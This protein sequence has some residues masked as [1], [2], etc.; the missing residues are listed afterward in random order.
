VFP[1]NGE[2]TELSIPAWA[3]GSYLIRDFAAQVENLR[4]SGGS[5]RTLQATKMSKNSWLIDTTEE[6]HFA[7]T[8]DIWAGMLN[9]STSWV[10]P[11][12]ALLNGSSI[13]MYTS[14]SRN[15]PQW[16][17]LNL[18]DDWQNVNTTLDPGAEP[19]SFLARDFDELV[20][21]PIL[22]G[23]TQSHDFSVDEQD[24]ALVL[25]TPNPF[26]DG[27]KS[28]EDLAK[29]VAAQQ[30][31][32]Q[33]NPFQKKYLFMNLFMGP[34]GGLEHDNSTVLM[35]DPLAM[36][37]R[38]QYIR[39]LGLVSHEFFH[40]WNV[41]RMRPAA[42][43]NYDY[44]R[45]MYTR[46]LWL[47]EGLSSYYDNLLLLRAGL[48]SV[49]E[50]L[51]LLA[52]EIRTYETTPG[53]EVRSAEM[54][55]F[56]TWIKHYRQDENSVNST[57]SYYRKGALI[58]F[59][60][61][62]AIRRATKGD[63]SLDTVM[64]R[65]YGRYS[66]PDQG[67]Y[68]PG[69]FED[70]VEEIAGPEVRAMVDNMLRS[71]GDPDV[72]QALAW[73]GL[74]LIRTPGDNTESGSEVISPAGLGVI[75]DDEASQL[76]VEQVVRGH[77]ASSA[78]MLPGDEL[79]AIADQRVTPLNYEDILNRLRPGEPVSLTVA[80][81]G[82]LMTLQA[83]V[84]AAIPDIYRIVPDPKIRNRQKKRMEEWLGLELLITKN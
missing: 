40:A 15:A 9:V 52:A 76:L 29:I 26:W 72:D 25:A 46:E 39:W 44:G 41:R 11:T 31:F 12:V 68:P 20:D 6:T 50:Y 74:V 53:R 64:R 24:Y 58:G 38:K 57:V 65:L 49:A 43:A 67:G 80:R 62:M 59:V 13:F 22:A 17:R 78:G 18:P 83:E 70:M 1:A 7:V 19:N 63:A 2:E 21:S 33:E 34:F 37:D 42:L 5:G 23:N 66:S 81:H 8:Y 61:D 55:S 16:V 36:R 54:A 10:E 56:D 35:I 45:E 73:Y 28:T 75:W 30:A 60:T 77:A 84:Q 71:T 79:I 69:A 48:I 82:R 14:S 27:E 3:P 47:A 32:W 4:V 51:E